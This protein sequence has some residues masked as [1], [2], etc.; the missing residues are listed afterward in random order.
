MYNPGWIQRTAAVQ[1]IENPPGNR[2]PGKN[3]QSDPRG[4]PAGDNGNVIGGKRQNADR[5][6]NGLRH[7]PA[8]L[9]ICETTE[10]DL[11]QEGIDQADIHGNR[12]EVASRDVFIVNQIMRDGFQIDK[13]PANIKPGQN[14]C[15]SGNS[16]A[17]SAEK[18]PLSLPAEV[19]KKGCIAADE[20]GSKDNEAEK[21]KFNNGLHKIGRL[22]HHLKAGHGSTSEQNAQYDQQGS[23]F[24]V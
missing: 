6:G 5:R 4:E 15:E 12:Q 16:K 24:L 17:K 23:G 14:Q 13:V 2:K 7:E 22:T 1:S 8:Q 9:Q 19:L 10:K 21:Q 18:M 20:T 11:F 3:Q